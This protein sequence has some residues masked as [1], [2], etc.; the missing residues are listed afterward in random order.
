[1]K[2]YPAPWCSQEECYVGLREIEIDAEIR[3]INRARGRRYR[4]ERDEEGW[5]ALAGVSRG[6]WE[7]A[8]AR[9]L[10]YERE[11]E[12]VREEMEEEGGGEWSECSS[13]GSEE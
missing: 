8:E 1:M 7:E 6:V 13:V 3:E 11:L 4:R 10:G 12:V 2:M 9:W 5:R